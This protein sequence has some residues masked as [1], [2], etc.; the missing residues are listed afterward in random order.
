MTVAI[1]VGVVAIIAGYWMAKFDRSRS[2]AA[3][4]AKAASSLGRIRWHHMITAVLLL[5]I[6]VAVIRALLIEDG[7]KDNGPQQPA[8]TGTNQPVAR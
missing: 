5:V 6:V 8:P 2:D 4:A 7:Y 1:A 3:A